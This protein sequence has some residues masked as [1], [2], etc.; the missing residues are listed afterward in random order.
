MNRTVLALPVAALALALAG[1]AIPAPA[2]TR[3][4]APYQT[5]TGPP[6][7]ETTSTPPP[8]F[9]PGPICRVFALDLAVWQQA[10]NQDRATWW[11]FRTF[12]RELRAEAALA[13]DDQPLGADLAAAAQKVYDVGRQTLNGGSPDTS[14]LADDLEGVKIDCGSP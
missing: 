8:Y 1:C 11:T 10:G 12:A 13:A 7:P 2:A 4:P 3:S 9:P 6:P 14:G 5:P